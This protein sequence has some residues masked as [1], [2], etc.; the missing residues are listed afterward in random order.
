MAITGRTGADAVFKALKRQCI[1]FQKYNTKL[2]A[3][4]LAAEA[5]T[6]IT[7]TEAAVCNAF[8]DSILTA[9]A[10]FEKVAGYSGF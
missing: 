5:A 4:I 8:L 6:I 1:V 2:R 10:A 9:C 3:V 7:S